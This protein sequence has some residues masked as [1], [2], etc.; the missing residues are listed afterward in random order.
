[1]WGKICEEG[2]F[3]LEECFSFR[4][5]LWLM[6]YGYGLPNTDYGGW[7]MVKVF[8]MPGNYGKRVNEE[9]GDS[10]FFGRISP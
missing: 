5:S 4:H 3:E 1:M 2:R 8:E 7:L 10:R 9:G 6:G